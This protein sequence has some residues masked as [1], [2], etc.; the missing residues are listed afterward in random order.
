MGLIET[1]VPGRHGIL[2]IATRSGELS[3]ATS[4]V[5]EDNRRQ[6]LIQTGNAK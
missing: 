6:S 5:I 1:R 4:W 3:I 2:G